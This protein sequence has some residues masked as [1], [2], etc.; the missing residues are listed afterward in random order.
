[1]PLPPSEGIGQLFICIIAFLDKMASPTS[2]TLSD[3]VQFIEDEKT[4]TTSL[5]DVEEE[6]PIKT[7]ESQLSRDKGSF[8]LR[9]RHVFITYP[10]VPAVPDHLEFEQLFI[11][12]VKA[13]CPIENAVTRKR[14]SFEYYGA[15]EYHA[16]GVPHYHVVVRFS[17]QPSIRNARAAFTLF[18]GTE[19]VTNAIHLLTPARTQSMHSFLRSTQGYA[20]KDST[21]RVIGKYINYSLKRGAQYDEIINAR[22][23]IECEAL[24]KEYMGKEW[25]IM[26]DRLRA[27]AASRDTQWK[28]LYAKPTF[29]PRPWVL[30]PAVQQWYSDNFE[31]P[32]DGRYTALILIGGSRLGKTEW[33]Q[34]FGRPDVITSRWNIKKIQAG[35]SHL[36]INDVDIASFPYW[37]EVL[38]CQVQFNATDKFVHTLSVNFNRPTI[39]TCN[40]DLDPRRCPKVASYLAIGR[41]VVV[42]LHQPL[43][44][45]GELLPSPASSPPAETA[46]LPRKR[47]LEEVGDRSTR[48]LRHLLPKGSL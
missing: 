20:V 21:D 16:N 18:R 27:F 17:H 26:N 1:M 30:P 14:T 10:H 34:S 29:E 19:Q 46:S 37:R 5:S 11:S 13:I 39:W 33:A 12:R 38:G 4:S 43:F 22:N 23:A 36:V 35:S 44:G 7:I 45:T 3:G 15:Q 28:P 25:I 31:R 6:D 2:S 42:D 41:A 47:Q 8:R 40:P 48:K 32:V 9:S 24:M